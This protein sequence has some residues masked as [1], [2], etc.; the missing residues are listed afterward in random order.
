MT[1][2]HVPGLH[3]EKIALLQRVLV[4]VKELSCW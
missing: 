2:P 1:H 3:I 4:W